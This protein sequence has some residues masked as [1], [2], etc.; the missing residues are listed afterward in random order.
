MAFHCIILHFVSGQTNNTAGVCESYR[1]VVSWRW[2]LISD[3]LG[4][5]SFLFPFGGVSAP[6]HPHQVKI[7]PPLQWPKISFCLRMR[8]KGVREAFSHRVRNK[9][10]FFMDS[11][12]WLDIYDQGQPFWFQLAPALRHTEQSINTHALV[13]TRTHTHTAHSDSLAWLTLAHSH[14]RTQVSVQRYMQPIYTPVMYA[15]GNN[16]QF[17][18]RS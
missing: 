13:Q 11:K 5:F 9:L 1:S 6:P 7:L 3:W 16:K 12:H 2:L 8:G 4:C 18:W 14:T 17:R 15:C 10:N